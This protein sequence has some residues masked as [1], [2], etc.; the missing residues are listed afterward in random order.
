LTD[1][2]FQTPP[3]LLAQIR[4]ALLTHLPSH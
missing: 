2:S 1:H 4:A 3:E